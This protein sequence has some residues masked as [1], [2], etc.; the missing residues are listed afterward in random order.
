LK[1]LFLKNK[2]MSEE[3]ED[4]EFDKNI[5][6]LQKKTLEKNLYILSMTIKRKNTA[7]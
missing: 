7:L 2:Y 6:K 5:L 4:S 1:Q 3:I